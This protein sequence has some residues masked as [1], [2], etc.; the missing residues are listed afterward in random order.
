MKRKVNHYHKIKI[1]FK[2]IQLLPR[3]ISILFLLKTIAKKE[4]SILYSGLKAHM[5]T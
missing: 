3:K 5:F 1:Q 2:P 4:L